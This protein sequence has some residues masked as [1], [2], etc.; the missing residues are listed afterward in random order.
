MERV[1]VNKSVRLAQTSAGA[2]GEKKAAVKISRR[3]VVAGVGGL[4]IGLVGGLALSK[5]LETG[6]VA[7]APPGVW[8]RVQRIAAERKLSADDVEAAVKTYLPGGVPDEFYMFASGGQS[9]QI[10]VLGLPSLKLYRTIAIFSPDSLSGW[11]PYGEKRAME[12]MLGQRAY[13]IRPLLWGDTHHPDL[14]RQNAEYV[15]RWLFIGDKA[16]GRAAAVSLLIFYPT[17]IVKI[18]NVQTIHGGAFTTP[19]TEYVAFDTQYPAPWEPGKGYK[20]GVT[21]VPSQVVTDERYYWEYMRG[22]ITFLAF[23]QNTGKFDLTRSFQIEVPPYVQDL[24][25]ISWGPGDGLAFANS[26]GTEGM[27]GTTPYEVK[28]SRNDYDLL[29]VILWRKA[30]DLCLRQGRC[31]EIN[32]IKVLSLD[33]AINEGVLFF[34]REPKSPHGVDT[35]PGGH[36]ISVGGK[37]AP[38]ATIYSTEKIK[39]AIADKKFEGKDRYGVP[40]LDYG[41]VVAAQVE[42]CLG[43]LH[44][45]FDGRGNAYISCFVSNE[46]VKFTLGQP[47]YT[48]P[49]PFSVVDKVPINYNVGHICIPESNSPNPAGKYLVAL[50]KWSID[51]F[52]NVGPLFPKNFQLID[53]SGEKMKVLLDM[54]VAFAETHYAKAIRREKLEKIKP[55]QVAP[56]GSDFLAFEGG[57]PRKDENALTTVG[58]ESVKRY[59]LPDGSWVT[60]VWGTLIRSTIRPNI[61]TA[62]KG[63]IVRLHLT[64]VEQSLNAMHG[65]ALAEY[66]IIAETEP[67]RYV[68]VEFVADVPGVF[69]FYCFD[70]C[71]PLHLEMAG[72]LVVEE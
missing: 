38:Y 55:L 46:V 54:P 7:P 33:D 12:V 56:T 18:P 35:S 67:G 57:Q 49:R 42:V 40:I 62:K 59:Q 61:I 10:H 28:L 11:G 71:S 58:K 20:P 52:M 26:F 2:S 27:F 30:E 44:T 19:N 60:E 64:N 72:W 65:F 13:G 48:G 3:E 24:M 15:G 70:F 4:A 21:K 69:A 66:G 43:P 37:L 23:D 5:L 16:N 22:A 47:E 45:E 8:E 68:E 39:Q 50:N 17:D 63:D 6:A 1:R 51:R 25:T 29:H 9:G 31:K 53:I 34:I 41:S 32:G 14:D 36:F